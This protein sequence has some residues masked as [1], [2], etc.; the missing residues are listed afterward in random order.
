MRTISS[1]KMSDSLCHMSSNNPALQKMFRCDNSTLS[2]R[3]LRDKKA[4]E[5]LGEF[6]ER[7][8]VRVVNVVEPANTSIFIAVLEELARVQN[9][10]EVLHIDLWSNGAPELVDRSFGKRF[11]CKQ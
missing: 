6:L 3:Y 2:L 4:V 11:S 5:G 8:V 9:R 1:V 10:I 7:G